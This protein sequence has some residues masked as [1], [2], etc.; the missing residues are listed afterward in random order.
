M[1]L[2]GKE[3]PVF[4]DDALRSLYRQEL[5]PS[6]VLIIIDGEITTELWKVIKKY[7]DMLPI[8]TH[9]LEHNVGLGKALSIGIDLC[10]NE[11]IARFDTDDVCVT[12][13]FKNQYNFMIEN[14]DI[15]VVGSWIAEFEFEPNHHHAIKKTPVS[16]QEILEFSKY[17][18]P[19]N[20][21]SVMYKKSSILAAGGYQDDYLYEDYALWVRMIKNGCV[22]A[23]IPEVL[24]YA[25]TGN[26]METRRGGLKYAMSEVKAQYSFYE[27]GF[28][29]LAE[30]MRNL[31][32]RV[33]VRLL[34]GSVRKFI[35][36]K[37]LR[38]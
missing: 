27:I 1:S 22:T 17:R 11:Y 9:E 29:S 5:L 16:H 30:L 19:F 31:A 26:G 14:A 25:R 8:I 4:L 28:L 36:R 37:T 38:R 7:H 21:M 20:H 33:P 6:E 24:V 13:R 12:G 32:I 18:N 15:D 10:S 34:P 23:N 2:Y 35:Y 3:S